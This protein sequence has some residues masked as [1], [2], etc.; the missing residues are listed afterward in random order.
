MRARWEGAGAARAELQS[1]GIRI[2]ISIPGRT[3]VDA[4]RAE[5]RGAR[6]ATL[7]RLLLL[8]VLG[9]PT[10]SA[11]NGGG[12]VAL[13]GPGVHLSL[14]RTAG[15]MVVTWSTPLTRTPASLRYSRCSPPACNPR[16]HPPQPLSNRVA[17]HSTTLVNNQ[18]AANL[19]V[20]P[21]RNISVHTALIA[22]IQAEEVIFYAVS[23]D[24]DT[25]RVLNFSYTVPYERPGPV[26]F[27]V[28]GDLAIKEQDG[29]NYTLSRLKQHHQSGDFDAVLHVGDIAYDLRQNAG[30]TGDEFLTD[31]EEVASSV[32]YMTVVGNHERDCVKAGGAEPLGDCGDP[33][34]TNYRTRFAMPTPLTPPPASADHA[35][36]YWSADIGAAHIIALNTDTYLVPGMV[37]AQ[38]TALREQLAWLR[39]D[40]SAATAPAQRAK[41]PWIIAMGHEMLYSSHDAGHQSQ[42]KLLREGGTGPAGDFEG[43]EA[44]FHEFG[45]DLYFS[46]HE[47]A[48]APRNLSLDH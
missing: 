41:V 34:Y 20:L 19:S 33:P 22:D 45:V 18:A 24:P 42:A 3:A 2:R 39:A 1:A 9:A 28:F 5:A 47:H 35:P 7:S 48:R 32:P 37:V 36:M 27:A 23:G 44:L 14:G 4:W 17:A 26:T 29:A 15:E 31:M 16:D 12:G 40:L 11:L 21:W 10:T 43:L 6:M 25:T 8:L 13:V 38:L 46:G 30:R